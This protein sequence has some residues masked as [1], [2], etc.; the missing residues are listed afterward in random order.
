MPNYVFE[1][2]VHFT[3][4]VFFILDVNA[5]VGDGRGGGFRGS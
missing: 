1:V 2:P 5:K 3:N 4:H